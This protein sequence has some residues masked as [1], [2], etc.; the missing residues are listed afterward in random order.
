MPGAARIVV[1]GAT[2]FIGRH[3]VDQLVRRGDD[4][5]A[6]VRDPVSARA[7]LPATVESVSSDLTDPATLVSAM[8]GATGVVHLAG[9]YRVGIPRSER[10][11]MLD[12]NVGAAERVLDAAITAA[13]ARV[14]HVSTVNVFGNTKGVVVDETYRRDVSAG[15]LSYYDETKWLAHQAA[16][17]RI[18]DGAPIVIV[19]PS[20]VYGPGDH[21]S[22]GEQLRQAHDGTLAF[23]GLGGVGLGFVHADDL[24]TGILAALDR[25]RP[26][27]SYILGG[28]NVRLREAMAIAAKVGGRPLPRISVPDTVLR[29]GAFLGPHLGGLFGLPPDLG[30]IVSASIGVTYWASS[31]RAATE[32]GYRPRDLATGFADTF[33]AAGGTTAASDA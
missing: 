28:P 20:Q 33:A 11:H 21:S 10:P 13:V 30:E 16:E 22:I 19:Q 8:A 23:I 27:A 14:V 9:S 17:R 25:G 4:V 18:R 24:A 5:T 3:V 31:A 29:V 15:F 6:L 7:L 32:L 26:G 1:T 2:G 12:A